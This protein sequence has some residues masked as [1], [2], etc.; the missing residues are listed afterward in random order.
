MSVQDFIYHIS[1]KQTLHPAQ[2]K[3]SYPG[4]RL[5][6]VPHPPMYGWGTHKAITSHNFFSFH[7]VL[8]GTVRIRIYDFLSWRRIIFL[9]TILENS[10]PG[11]ITP[12]PSSQEERMLPLWHHSH[13]LSPGQW[14]HFHFLQSTRKLHVSR[15][16]LKKLHQFFYGIW[17]NDLGLCSG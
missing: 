11:S 3:M 15:P 13:W 8:W 14:L 4:P 6:S 9:P 17:T 5:C 7:L 1:S 10:S 2:S 12:I 16:P